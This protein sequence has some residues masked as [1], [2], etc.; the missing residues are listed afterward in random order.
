[1]N[2]KFQHTIKGAF[3]AFALSLIGFV[4]P[5][6]AADPP[7]QESDAQKRAQTEQ[8]EARHQ[9]AIAR[10][11]KAAAANNDEL[12]WLGSLPAEW[13]DEDFR[14]RFDEVSDKIKR[15][16]MGTEDRDA[17]RFVCKSPEQF[18]PAPDWQAVVDFIGADASP[19]RAQWQALVEAARKGNWQARFQVFLALSRG[20]GGDLVSR[21]RALQLMEWLQEHHVGGLYAYFMDAIAASGYFD[22]RGPRDDAP[23]YVYAAMHG[24]YSAMMRVGE[25]L[26]DDDDP[27]AQEI[28]KS[29][30]ECAQK[31]MPVLFEE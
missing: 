10:Y 20:R 27:K 28:G 5:A 31:M 8:G 14:K 18:G 25:K 9:E 4:Q 29:M 11:R 3:A 21:W 17:S 26:M 1:M 16:M 22:G 24:S 30:R 19:T 13:S 2:R 7:A 15:D 6:H 12:A 23:V